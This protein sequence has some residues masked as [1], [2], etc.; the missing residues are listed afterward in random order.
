MLD[1][2][3]QKI[4]VTM[5]IIRDLGCEAEDVSAKE[6]FDWMRLIETSDM[7]DLP[8]GVLYFAFL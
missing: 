3:R 2:I 8:L 6:F 4:D 5:K 1:E 7:E